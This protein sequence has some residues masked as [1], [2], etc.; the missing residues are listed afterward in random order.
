LM[1]AA[2]KTGSMARA[3]SGP[4]RTISSAR[5]RLVST[6]D[7]EKPNASLVLGLMVEN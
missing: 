5:T 4:T 2:R 1:A 6:A 7:S 3:R